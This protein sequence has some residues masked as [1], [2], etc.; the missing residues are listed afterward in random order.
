VIPEHWQAVTRADG[1]TVGYVAP[2]HDE[3]VA[4]DLLGHELGRSEWDDEA[5]ALVVERGLASLGRYWDW[6]DAAGTT[7]RVY[8]QHVRPGSATVS[9]GVAGVVGA[10]GETFTVDLPVDPGRFRPA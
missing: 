5:R 10:T 4:F 7:R 8:V 6:T 1:E 9:T 2:E 3:V